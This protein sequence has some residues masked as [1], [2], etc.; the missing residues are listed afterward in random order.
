MVEASEPI[1]SKDNDERAIKKENEKNDVKEMIAG[2]FEV[3]DKDALDVILHSDHFI[4]NDECQEKQVEERSNYYIRNNPFKDGDELPDDAKSIGCKWVFKT[5]KDSNGNIERHKARLIAKEFTQRKEIDYTET[6]SPVC[7]KPEIAY[8]VGVLG[9]YQS[10]PGVD[11]RKAAKKVMRYLQGA[12]DFMLMYRQTNLLEMVSYSDSDYAVYIDTRKS[13]SD[14]VFMLAGGAISWK[15]AKQ[16]ITATS[17]M[18]AE[19]I[20]CFNTSSHGTDQVV[21]SDVFMAKN[22]KSGSRSR[23][24]HIDIKYLALRERVKENKV[25]IEH[26]STKLMA[27]DPLTKYMPLRNFRDHVASYQVCAVPYDYSYTDEC[28]K[29]PRGPQYNGGIVINPEL[30]EGLKGWSVHGNAKVKHAQSDDGNKYIIASERRQPF[31]SFSQRFELEEG[32]LYSFS[33]WAQVSQG[34]ASIKVVLKTQRGYQ[35]AGWVTARNGCWSMAKGGFVA[36]TSGFAYLYFESE[37]IEVDIWA[38]N[39]SLQPFTLEEWQS[40]RDKSIEMVRKRRVKFYIKN[41]DGSP[42]KNTTL[43]IKPRRQNFPFGCAI[44]QN[45]LNNQAYQDWFFSRF[46]Y[47]VFENEMKWYSTE[48][49]PGKED[50]SKSDALMNLAKSRGVTVRGH[51]VFWDDPNQQPSWVKGLGN[52]DFSKAANNRLNSVVGRYKGQLI[53]WDVLNE[54]L[55]FDYFEGKLGRNSAAKF[56]KMTKKIDGKAIPF[57]NDYNTIEDN[58]DSS[59][60]PTKYLKKIKKIRRQGYKGPLGIGLESHFSVAPNLPYIRSA[61]DQ[62]SSAKLPIWI[63]ELDVTSGPNQ[64]SYLE[65]ILGEVYGHRAVQGILIWSAWSSGGCY[66]MCLTDNNFKNLPTGDVVDKFRNKMIF[67]N[68]VQ[69]LTTN[70]NGFVETSLFH[71]EYEV[72]A[73]DHP[74]NHYAYG[75]QSYKLDTLGI[76]TSDETNANAN[77]KTIHLQ[78]QL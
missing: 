22:N 16:S 12:K 52:A 30:N 24:K 65:E 55:H 72:A 68:Q 56:Y 46:K 42:A 28:L 41:K 45:I 76:A 71:G 67:P 51:N 19:F 20:S 63:T 62:L 60:L 7:T 26:V 37:N 57:L 35:I 1:I 75:N 13:T 50:Y 69:K 9:R 73:H 43:S 8:F 36:Q 59:S 44:N 40:H 14:Y 47:T 4:Y 38:D 31:H 29:N 34:K 70:S 2:C 17:T 48:N 77:A 27:V 10:N 15:S 25:V 33:G 6:F 11:H 64:A 58:R 32:K 61:L 21:L 5:K 66:R 49:T 53:H 23:S 39:I 78:L 74:Y 18:E 54:N 3:R